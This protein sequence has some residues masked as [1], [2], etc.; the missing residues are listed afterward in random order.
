MTTED[1]CLIKYVCA[2]RGKQSKKG[3]ISH[4]ATA[5]V[6]GRDVIQ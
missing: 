1:N 4:L 3:N 5:I 2:T 6:N